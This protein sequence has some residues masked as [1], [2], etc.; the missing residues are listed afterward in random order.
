MHAGLELIT[1]K[2]GQAL[3]LHLGGRLDNTTVTL[4]QQRV[5]QVLAVGEARIVV[6]LARLEYISSAGMR[7]L[8]ALAMQLR[9]RPDGSI[10][11]ARPQGMVQDVL[12]LAGFQ[13]MFTMFDS[14][15]DA[16]RA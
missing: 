8:L 16:V 5:E 7:G 12:R 1:E 13:Q 2:R 11:F 15:E 9:S 14:L 6:D 3:V 4:F 10:A